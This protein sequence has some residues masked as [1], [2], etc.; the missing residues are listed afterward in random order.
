[1]RWR[2][3]AS[4]PLGREQDRRLCRHRFCEGL[5]AYPI[6]RAAWPSM[7]FRS[8]A[9]AP[10]ACWPRPSSTPSLWS[11]S[12][13]T[14]LRR[15]MMACGCGRIH[16]VR[17]CNTGKRRQDM[18]PRANA[19]GNLVRL[20]ASRQQRVRNQCPVATPRHRLGAHQDD[21]LPLRQVDTRLQAVL[22]CCG[23]HV[24]GI[25]TEAG[26]APGRVDGI[27]PRT[28]Q[29]TQSRHV[30]IVD[31]PAVKRWRQLVAIELG[32]VS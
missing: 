17:A 4:D 10:G 26:V 16:D 21:A 13:A 31:V 20:D 23:L 18:R 29:T 30:P 28:A 5:P 14:H 15:R 9:P 6:W 2:H 1:M 8:S 32:I 3:V 7:R 25:A 12:C 27:R 19:A 24:V 11:E 22:E